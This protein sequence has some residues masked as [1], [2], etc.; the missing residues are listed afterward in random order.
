MNDKGKKK[1]KEIIEHIEL[2]S[3]VPFKS[4]LVDG[5]EVTVL[6]NV[7]IT[8]Q[9]YLYRD[10]NIRV[11]VILKKNAKPAH[12]CTKGVLLYEPLKMS[13]FDIKLLNKKGDSR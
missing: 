10:S 12:N 9:A 7:A 8:G 5:K 2:L 13:W 6:S 11:A 4:K 1:G 3:Q